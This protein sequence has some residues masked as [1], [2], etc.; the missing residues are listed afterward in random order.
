MIRRQFIGGIGTAGM[1]AS[2]LVP[3]WGIAP[4]EARLRQ[5]VTWGGIYQEDTAHL[6]NFRLALK[7][8]NAENQS[9]NSLLVDMI[10][11]VDWSKTNIDLAPLSYQASDIQTDLGMATVF[12]AEQDLA[13][14][15]F[16]HLNKTRYINRLV[17]Y[18]TIYNVKKRQIIANFGVLG[19][20][21]ESLT[22]KPNSEVLPGIYFD[23]VTNKNR[24]DSIAQHLITKVAR[25]PY[26][27][28]YGGKRFR[29]TKVS[30]SSLA[31]SKANILNMDLSSLL[32]QVGH[33]AGISFSS[34]LNV[35]IIPYEK[36]K[37]LNLDLVKDMRIIATDGNSALNTTL[38]LSDPEIGIEIK[39]DGW[40]YQDKPYTGQ[41]QLVSLL[42]SLNVVIKNVK[43]GEVFFNQ[44][45][46]GEKHQFEIPS[47][48]YFVQRDA[49]VYLL[50]E[51]L[52]HKIFEAFANPNSRSELYEG[53]EFKQDGEKTFLQASSENEKLF[54]DE[55]NAVI[56]HLPYAMG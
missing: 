15:Y 34:N 49:Y 55:H 50:H 25:Y 52:L 28:T 10:R 42:I 3:S 20:Y 13:A 51:E 54:E 21:Y 40:D 36:S 44:N 33:M 23:L 27:N 56:K 37:T 1:A 30:G 14:I 19:R 2:G 39:L 35:P 8:R 47:T 5:P 45:Y 41:R 32:D 22:G 7:M 17:G 24:K 26:A 29:V 38:P 9:I 31:E 18:N 16:P 53:F 46:Y 4:A 43:S 6:P 12:V 48:G 11:Q